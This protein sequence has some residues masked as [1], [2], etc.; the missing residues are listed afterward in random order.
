M[1]ITK[2]DPFKERSDL[3]AVSGG[4]LDIHRRKAVSSTFI[5]FSLLLICLTTEIFLKSRQQI[6]RERYAVTRLELKYFLVEIETLASFVGDDDDDSAI[7]RLCQEARF[8]CSSPQSASLTTAEIIARREAFRLAID[9]EKQQ[10]NQLNR[11]KKKLRAIIEDVRANH[12]H[13]EAMC[14][15]ME[16]WLLKSPEADVTVEAIDEKIFK[17]ES[18][19]NTTSRTWLSWRFVVIILV[20]LAAGVFH[21]HFYV[22]HD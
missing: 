16:D 11:E 10:R 13:L 3:T 15:A 6:N 5:T 21:N 12:K 14:A 22:V 1:Q 9:N 8:W 2:E 17:L 20:M 7:P 4:E 19:V 18:E